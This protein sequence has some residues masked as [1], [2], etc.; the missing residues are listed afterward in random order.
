MIYARG[1]NVSWRN[2]L[3]FTSVFLQKIRLFLD[4]VSSEM[5]RMLTSAVIF[6][7]NS[8]VQFRSNVQVLLRLNYVY[9]CISELDLIRDLLNDR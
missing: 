4:F 9:W 7:D 6:K 2:C 1:F 5:S 3:L 8:G